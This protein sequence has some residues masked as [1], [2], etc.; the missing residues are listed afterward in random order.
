MKNR[1]TPQFSLRTLLIGAILLPA[2]IHVAMYV[3][4]LAHVNTDDVLPWLP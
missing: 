3:W 4:I 2:V 1:W